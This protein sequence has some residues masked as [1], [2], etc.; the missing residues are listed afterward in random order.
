MCAGVCACIRRNFR[1]VVAVVVRPRRGRCRHPDAEATT[2]AAAP[3]TVTLLGR[4][5]V[6]EAQ[7]RMLKPGGAGPSGPQRVVLSGAR[8][9]RVSNFQ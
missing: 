6:A 9:R 7:L 3:I 8:G 4:W 1:V 2:A 5:A